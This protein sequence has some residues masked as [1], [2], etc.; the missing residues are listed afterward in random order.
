MEHPD[1]PSIIDSDIGGRVVN[2]VA[3]LIDHSNRSRSRGDA[4]HI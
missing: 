1:P 4:C 3:S 2:G